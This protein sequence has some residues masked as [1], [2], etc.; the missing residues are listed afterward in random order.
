MVFFVVYVPFV[1]NRF[2][3]CAFVPLFFFEP[4]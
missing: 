4:H 3:L 1:A 2:Q